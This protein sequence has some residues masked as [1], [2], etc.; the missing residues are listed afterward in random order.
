MPWFLLKTKQSEFPW[1]L[2]QMVSW[3]TGSLY[4]TLGDVQGAPLWR[5]IRSSTLD[6]IWTQLLRCIQL[7]RIFL[8]I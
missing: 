7:L 4:M 1:K 2:A 5:G 6:I 3:E 8:P